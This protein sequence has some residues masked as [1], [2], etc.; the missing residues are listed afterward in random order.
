[1][2]RYIKINT[3]LV[4]CLAFVVRLLFLNLG[5]F[6]ST[7]NA[8]Q[9]RAKHS[10]TLKK[11]KINTEF[12]DIATTNAYSPMEFCEEANNEDDDQKINSPVLLSVLCAFLYKLSFIPKPNL[13][14]DRLKSEL[15]PKRYLSLSILRI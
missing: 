5:V 1:M 8:D 15:F 9:L 4:I 3:A 7:F 12:K 6:S 11:R 10:Y 14:F 13:S 2:L